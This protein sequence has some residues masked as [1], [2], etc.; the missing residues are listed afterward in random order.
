MSQTQRRRVAPRCGFTFHI[1]KP[2][3]AT[4]NYQN[5]RY[6]PSLLI[7]VADIPSPVS[8]AGIYLIYPIFDLR[9][10]AFTTTGVLH[11]NAVI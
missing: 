1:I 6:L 4:V 5:I 3:L 11:A 9:Y 7:N 2:Q 10:A 8:D